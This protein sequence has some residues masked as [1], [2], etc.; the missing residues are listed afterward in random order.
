MGK[1]TGIAL[2]RNEV[3]RRAYEIYLD[4]KGKNGSATGDWLRAEEEIRAKLAKATKAKTTSTP[5]KSAR[6]SQR[7]AS[8]R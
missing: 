2:D 4:R 1:E 8:A 7:S 5:T 3:A 6:P